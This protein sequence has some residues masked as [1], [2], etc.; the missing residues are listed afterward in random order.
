[1]NEAG[2]SFRPGQQPTARGDSLGA[3]EPAPAP[4][5]AL[6]QAQCASRKPLRSRRSFRDHDRRHPVRPSHMAAWMNRCAVHFKAAPQSGPAS[7]TQLR[8]PRS[9]LQPP[10]VQRDCRSRALRAAASAHPVLPAQV[11]R[12]ASGRAAVCRRC[13]RLPGGSTDVERLRVGKAQSAR[14]TAIDEGSSRPQAFADPVVAPSISAARSRQRR[15]ALHCEPADRLAPAA[16]RLFRTWSTGIVTRRRRNN[17]H[18]DQGHRPRSGK[19]AATRAASP[20][21]R[22]AQAMP[23]AVRSSCVGPP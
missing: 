7:T 1:V 2:L 15:E 4:A 5:P 23:R 22:V 12:S 3:I 14:R 21:W 19:L 17:I 10:R 18:S 11:A 6:R 20:M 8:S 9:P 13:L 16:A